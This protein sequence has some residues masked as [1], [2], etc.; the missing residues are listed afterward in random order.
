MTAFA[1][2]ARLHGEKLGPYRGT[3]S[4]AEFVQDLWFG[5][6]VVNTGPHR[7]AAVVPAVDLVFT[8]VSDTLCLPVDLMMSRPR[9]KEKAEK[10]EGAAPEDME[11]HGPT[12]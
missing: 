8:V 9:S 2:N 7:W 3:R 5:R 1:T 12:E 11:T 6:G 10:Q 4:E